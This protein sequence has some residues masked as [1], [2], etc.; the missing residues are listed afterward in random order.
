MYSNYFKIEFSFVLWVW[1]GVWKLK[2]KAD[3]INGCP[4]TVFKFLDHLAPHWPKVE[5]RLALLIQAVIFLS[6]AKI[7][8]FLLESNTIQFHLVY[9]PI[10]Q[11]VA[12]SY[13]ITYKSIEYFAIEHD[14][15]TCINYALKVIYL[16]RIVDEFHHISFL[17]I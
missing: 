7:F 1:E 17:S 9:V 4:L 3:G 2:K 10:F 16:P 13:L 11:H 8:T 6:L 14:S 12:N 5:F 15:K